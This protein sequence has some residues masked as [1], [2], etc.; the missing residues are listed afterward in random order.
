[1]IQNQT[2]KIQFYKYQ[3]T[4]N[5]FIIIDNR[6]ALLNNSNFN[7]EIISRLCDRRFGIGADGLMLLQNHPTVNFKM[8]YF[9]SDGRE[10]SLCGNGSRCIIAFAKKMGVIDRKAA[11]E[12][13]DGLHEAE[14]VDFEKSIV[15]FKLQDIS[16]VEVNNQFYFLDNG[17][18]HYVEFREDAEIMDI[19]KYGREIR[20]N[21]RFKEFGTNVNIVTRTENHLFV[22]T[23]ERGVEDETLSCGTGVTASAI[24]AYFESKNH[25]TD[26]SISTKGGK[27]RVTYKT[28]DGTYF[29]NIWLEGPA[30][31]V[32]EGT[33]DI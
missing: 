21:D 7:Q 30:T 13:V 16:Y 3:G 6:N 28:T 22:R 23:Y 29:S 1:M 25:V 4:G 19:V 32:F 10:G 20:Y 33:I 27:L 31:F 9:N 15:R 2:M 26:Y 14:V 5:D 12:A 24:S 11:F 18:L 17:S 8:R